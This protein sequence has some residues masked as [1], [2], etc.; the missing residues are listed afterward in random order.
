M[1]ANEV[2][3][4]SM[5]ALSR[6]LDVQ[7]KTAFVLA[8]KLREAMATEVKVLRLGG[9]G[10]VAEVD[11][12]YFG[13]YLRPANERKDRVDRRKIENRNGKEQVVVAIRERNGRTLPRVF[14]SE[15]E[16]T[17]FIRSRLAKGTK[18]H[19]D[20]A[21]GWNSLHAVFEVN[22]I[23]HKEAYSLDGACTNWAE[24]F[25]SRIRRGEWGHHHHISGPYLV[26]F[27][28][29]AAGQHRAAARLWS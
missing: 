14:K 11:G 10:A 23:N 25:F 29:E 3:G 16:S 12:A 5:L 21:P 6:S 4:K 19:A 9:D 28:Q 2:K 20:E 18:L 22:R 24:S 15:A 8:H 13:G 1:F 26:K 17:G 27:A 7:Y